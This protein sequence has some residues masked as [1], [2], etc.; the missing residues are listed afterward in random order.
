MVVA[1]VAFGAAVIR[2][3][4]LPRWTGITLIVGMVLMAVTVSL[5]DVTQTMSA[6]VRDL[7]FAGM[8]AAVVRHAQPEHRAAVS[9]SVGAS[10]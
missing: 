3:Q 7:A 10:G 4:V 9:L 2:A 8:G 5:P 1:G 6:A